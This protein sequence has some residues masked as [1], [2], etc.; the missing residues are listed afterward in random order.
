MRTSSQKELVSQRAKL[1]ERVK[2]SEQPRLLESEVVKVVKRD[3]VV[4]E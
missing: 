1:S 4:R 2:L 3:K